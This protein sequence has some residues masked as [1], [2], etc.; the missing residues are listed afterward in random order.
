[1][2]LGL[3]DLITSAD[4]ATRDSALEARCATLSLDELL[5]EC[6]ALDAFR[7][8]SG[9]LYDRVRALFF[10]AAIHRYHLPERLAEPRSADAPPALV[11]RTPSSAG[12]SKRAG[13]PRYERGATRG[14]GC[15]SPAR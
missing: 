1:M 15:I 2:S 12:A 5:A 6:A 11:A 3:L 9:N 4:P 13:R 14:R 8:T 10:L 7:R